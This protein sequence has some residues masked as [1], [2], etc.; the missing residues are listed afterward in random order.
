MSATGARSCQT[1]RHPPSLVRSAPGNTPHLPNHGERFQRLR[2]LSRPNS[3]LDRLRNTASGTSI[4]N[5]MAPDRVAPNRVNIRVLTDKIPHNLR[6]R[7]RPCNIPRQPLRTMQPRR[8]HRTM[9]P[10][11]LPPR[12]QP[13]HQ[14]PLR[15]VSKRLHP[16]EC[17]PPTQR[18]G[19]RLHNRLHKP[20]PRRMRLHCP[21]THRRRLMLAT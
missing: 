4:I 14:A 10:G 18:E 13:R 15:R 20:R 12:S 1:F 6:R 7:R 16:T 5:R 8:C 2:V 3:P 11:R 9:Q 19:T 21:H 17:L